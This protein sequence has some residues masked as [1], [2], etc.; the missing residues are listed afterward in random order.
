M[1]D[2]WSLDCPTLYTVSITLFQDV[3]ILDTTCTRFGF[4]E[5][6][7]CPDG[8]FYLNGQTDKLVWT[9]STPDLSLYWRSCAS[10]GC[11]ARM[12]IS[13]NMNWPVISCVPLIILNPLIFSIAV[14]R[15]AY[16]SSKKS[17]DGSILGMKNGRHYLF[18]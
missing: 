16:S 11:N 1:L 18:G 8:G 2:L 4:R 14:M 13:S 7:F 12:Q 15:S 17:Q 6:E 5:A 10:T 3:Q 9:E